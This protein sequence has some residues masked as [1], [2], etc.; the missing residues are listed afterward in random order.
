MCK[1]NKK[2]E[3]SL[4]CGKFEVGGRMTPPMNT[5]QSTGVS[6]VS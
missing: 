1:V 3:P 2:Q 6:S 4:I 5:K